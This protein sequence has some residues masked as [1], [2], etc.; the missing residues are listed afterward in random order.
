LMLE[1]TSYAEDGRALEFI[2]SIYNWRR[3]QFSIALPRIRM[4][5]LS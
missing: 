4:D 2:S 5:E 1:R 3:Y